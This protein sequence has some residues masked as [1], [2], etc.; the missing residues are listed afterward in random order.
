MQEL[1]QEELKQKLN[2]NPETGLF[3]WLIKPSDKI[4]LGSVAGSLD[5]D[6]YVII[7]LNAKKYRAHRLVWFYV[8]GKWPENEIDH[9]NRI[10]RDNR[11]I[12]LREAT[13]QENQFNRGEQ[14]NNTSGYKGVSWNKQN[15]KWLANIRVNCK[16]IY[17]GYFDDI[18][19]ASKAYRKAKEKYHII[20]DKL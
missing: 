1:M 2:Y 3:S 19:E 16:T 17:L 8:Y 14:K 18:Q 5:K 12:N 7:T 9:I 15:K 20:R 4:K 13:D 11:I 10:P 6:G